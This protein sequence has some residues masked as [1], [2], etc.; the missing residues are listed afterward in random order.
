MCWLLFSLLFFQIV[1]FAS[2]DTLRTPTLQATPLQQ[3]LHLDGRLTEPDW[4]QAPAATDFRQLEPVEGAAPTFPTAV[5]VLYG[6]DALYIGAM[7][8]D[9]E[10]HLI[11]RLVWC[12][13]RLILRP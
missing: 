13:N 8:Y 2:P 7:L 3:T 5:R 10:P 1:A 11:R 4:Q 12:R 6:P 9:P